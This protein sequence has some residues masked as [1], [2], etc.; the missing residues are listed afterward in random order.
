MRHTGLFSSH[1][2]KGF[3]LTTR[4]C[5]GIASIE[6]QE[7]VTSLCLPGDDA[8]TL[9]EITCTLSASYSNGYEKKWDSTSSCEGD[10]PT[11]LSLHA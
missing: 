10:L 4:E 3:T 5:I 9:S 6:E 8:H 7:A 2:I 1:E 11:E